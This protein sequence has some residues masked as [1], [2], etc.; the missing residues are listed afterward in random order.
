MLGG[1]GADVLFGSSGRDLLIGGRGRDLLSGGSDQDILIGGYTI[2]DNDRSALEQ[3]AL[4]WNSDGT[5]RERIE[6]LEAGV[7]GIALL[8]GVQVLN[9]DELDR[10]SGGSGL[11]W[12]FD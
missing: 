7:G 1:S 2:Y 4:E 12:S 8:A 10:L 6:R 11:D 9:D 3:I 5:W